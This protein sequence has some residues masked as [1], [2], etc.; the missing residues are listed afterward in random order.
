MSGAGAEPVAGLSE[1][2]WPPLS[3]VVPVGP[4]D[5][6]WHGLLP[7]LGTLPVSIDVVFCG[8][9]AAPVDWPA[10]A[11]SRATWLQAEQGRARQANAGSAH[12]ESEFVWW[13]HADSRPAENAFDALAQSLRAH[14]SAL[15]WFALRFFDGPWL[16]RINAAGANWRSRRFSLP[17]GDQGLCMARTQF[18]RL[19]GFD[20]SV[21]LGEDLSLVMRARAAGIALQ[22][23]AATIQTSARRYRLKGW[24][25]TTLRHLWLTWRLSRAER[26]RYAR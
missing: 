16:A 24:L 10:K 1:A 12:T 14:P 20:E 13:L 21:S 5:S 11:L 9:E 23:V 8:C 2:Q 3:V 6:S 18:H 17:F 22:E 26:A 25:S 15:H 7:F 4:G 19:G